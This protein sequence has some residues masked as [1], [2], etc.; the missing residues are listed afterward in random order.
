[1][2][3]AEVVAQVESGV[4]DE[5]AETGELRSAEPSADERRHQRFQVQQVLEG[6]APSTRQLLEAPEPRRARA[7]GR[8]AAAIALVVLAAQSVHHYRTELVTN[9]AVGPLVERTY[10]MLGTTVVPRWDIHQYEILDW[11]ATAEPNTRGQ[12]SLRI[13]ARIKN[14]GPQYQPY[15]SVHLRLKDRWEAAVGSRVFAPTGISRRRAAQADGTR[16]NDARGARSRRSGP[17]RLW[18]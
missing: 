14:R 13:T 3:V 15:P 2:S 4:A 8:R 17:R 18:I 1:M 7:C 11:I 9:A 6:E 16:R 12:G 10:A 5:D